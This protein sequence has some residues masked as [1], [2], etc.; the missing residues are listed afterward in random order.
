MIH[1]DYNKENNYPHGKELILF[2]RSGF[3]HAH[4]DVLC[5]IN[6]KYN[7]LCPQVFVME[8]LAP[9]NT[10]RKSDEELEIAKKSLREKFELIENPIVLTGDTYRSPVINIPHGYTLP[11]Y[12]YIR[13]N[14]GELHNSYPYNNGTRRPRETYSTL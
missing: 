5:E 7:I 6:K 3:Q 2:D 1:V 10:D 9:Q 11:K 12:S 4:R 8:C 13:R 14:C